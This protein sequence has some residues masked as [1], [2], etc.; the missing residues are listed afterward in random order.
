MPLDCMMPAHSAAKTDHAK[1]GPR[2]HW[3][4]RPDGTAV[5]LTLQEVSAI[6]KRCMKWRRDQEID[7]SPPVVEPDQIDLPAAA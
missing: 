4:E 1:S 2:V 7:V 3:G 6:W 5:Y